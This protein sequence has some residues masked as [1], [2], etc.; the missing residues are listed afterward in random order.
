MGCILGIPRSGRYRER[1]IERV[2]FRRFNP[3]G[4]PDAG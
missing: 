1:L 4:K 2:R 3:W